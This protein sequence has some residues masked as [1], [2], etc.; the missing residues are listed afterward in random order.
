MLLRVNPKF[1]QMDLRSLME[2]RALLEQE[3]GDMLDEL[4]GIHN[5]L[6]E[7][8]PAVEE[9]VTS[10]LQ[11]RASQRA[12]SPHVPTHLALYRVTCRYSPR[13]Y[14][15]GVVRRA[16]AAVA[17]GGRVPGIGGAR[18]ADR[19]LPL[20]LLEA[21]ASLRLSY[22]VIFWLRVGWGDVPVWNAGGPE[23]R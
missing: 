16:A 23:H 21:R 2:E 3:T 14:C 13:L 18:G 4:C 11:A 8:N 7:G 6:E 19:K 15:A 1:L 9:T 5:E 10:L 20:V 12:A 22:F 17:T